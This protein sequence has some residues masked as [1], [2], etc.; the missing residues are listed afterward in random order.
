MNL[1]EFM[2]ALFEPLGDYA[3]VMHTLI[4]DYKDE[5]G[6]DAHGEFF[7]MVPP[8]MTMEATA[9]MIV[10]DMARHG[11]KVMFILNSRNLTTVLKS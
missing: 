6:E 8:G 11:R 9:Q 2:N 7:P 1:S 5:N 10:E 3:P 4:I